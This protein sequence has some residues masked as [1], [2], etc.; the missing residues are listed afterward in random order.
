MSDPIKFTPVDEIPTP[1]RG[2]G[3]PPKFTK[4]FEYLRANPG[5]TVKLDGKHHTTLTTK[6]KRGEVSGCEA[7]EFFAVCRNANNGQAD[8]YVTY[9]GPKPNEDFHERT[10]AL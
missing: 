4:V 8:I 2:R 5:A 1:A 3:A 9:V 7:G 10:V 6:I